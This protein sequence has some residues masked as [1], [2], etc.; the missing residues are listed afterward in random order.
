[1]KEKRAKSILQPD[2]EKVCFISGSRIN[3]D[4][5]HIYH[6]SANRKLSDKYGCWVWIRHDLHRLLHDKDKDLDKYLQQECQ[7]KFDETHTRQDFIK[8][9]GKSYLKE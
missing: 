2:E 5:H 7:K 1:M 9:F 4:L 6:G 3:L 8:I